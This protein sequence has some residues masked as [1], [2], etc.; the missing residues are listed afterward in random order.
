MC[1]KKSVQF[2]D[3]IYFFISE[4]VTPIIQNVMYKVHNIINDNRYT[5]VETD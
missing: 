3:F 5:I 4:L 1:L 2:A